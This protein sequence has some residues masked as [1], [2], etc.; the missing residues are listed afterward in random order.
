M[1]PRTTSIYKSNGQGQAT[2]QTPTVTAASDV[3]ITTCNLYYHVRQVE[4]CHRL[5]EVARRSS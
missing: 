5:G 1:S 2:A 4:P 3:S